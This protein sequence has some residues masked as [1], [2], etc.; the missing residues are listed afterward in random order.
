MAHNARMRA[1]WT[2][3]GAVPDAHAPDGGAPGAGGGARDGG[4]RELV[5]LDAREHGAQVRQRRVLEHAEHVERQQRRDGPER[6]GKHNNDAQGQI[7]T[8][9]GFSQ[10]VRGRLCRT[11]SLKRPPVVVV[12]KYSRG[13]LTGG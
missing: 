8:L 3:H 9:F 4:E 10:Q 5:D 6:P 1:G 11:L 7:H 2:L 13:A 12:P